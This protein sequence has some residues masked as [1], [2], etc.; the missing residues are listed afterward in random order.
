MITEPKTQPSSTAVIEREA[1]KPI[2]TYVP[3][4]EVP[5]IGTDMSCKE[6]LAL[7]K[8][9]EDIPCV[10]VVD[11]NDLPLGIIMR[12]AYN[13]HFTGRF[14]AALFYDKPAAIFA[15]PDTLIV[16]LK[17]RASDIVELA[18]LREE[19]RFYDCVL[20][21]EGTRL[22][23]VLTIRDI[24]SVV[25]RM[26]R[27]ADEERGEVIRHSYDGVQRI[28]LTVLDA[29]KEAD[30]SVRLT[31]SMSELSRRGK[32]ELEDVLL[33]YRA[34]TEQMKRQHEQMTALTQ[35]LNDIAGMASSIRALADQSGLLAI[36]AS[37]EAAHAGEHGRGFQI[38]SQEVRNMSLQTKAFSTQITGLL[39]HIEQMLR[40]TAELTDT[41]M[42]QIHTGSQYISAGTQTFAKLLQAVD[43]I[44]AK[45]S[46]MSHSAEEAA[47]N[48][49]E[50]A[51][52]LELMLSS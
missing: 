29:A 2:T 7:M 4:R 5:I 46:E 10:I 11:K 33:S 8:T 28:Q 52:E 14:A 40:D 43:E 12:D 45:N 6:L 38:V 42:Q 49:A 3:C 15:D 36:N 24:L 37:I 17:S 47:L 19:Q 34:V 25:Q 21:K 31:R 26:Q 30:D 20:I 13:R 22:L 1:Y 41:S 32:V 51:Q 18:M 50:I 9:Q 48:A 44:E 16:D 27:E 39:T 35:S 23:G